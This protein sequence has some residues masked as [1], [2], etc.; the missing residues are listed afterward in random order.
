[1]PHVN[2]NNNTEQHI[3]NIFQDMDIMYY[4]QIAYNL[5]VIYL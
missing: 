2:N 4:K 1:M 3:S 5:Q